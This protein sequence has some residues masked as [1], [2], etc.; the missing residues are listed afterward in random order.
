[1][2]EEGILI[3]DITLCSRA[4]VM[5]SVMPLPIFWL[6]GRNYFSLA[7]I[8]SYFSSGN[9]KRLFCAHPFSTVI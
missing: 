8:Q 9:C 3:S 6:C 2:G 5:V 7:S 4:T 1:M